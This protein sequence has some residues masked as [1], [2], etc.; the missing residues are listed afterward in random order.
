MSSVGV[1]VLLALC[2]P[3][4]CSLPESPFYGSV[5]ARR[6]GC[7]FLLQ[8]SFLTQ[9]S[10]L[11]LLCLLQWQ[12]DALPLSHWG[13]PKCLELCL[14]QKA[15]RTMIPRSSLMSSVLLLLNQHH[16]TPNCYFSRRKRNKKHFKISSL[17]LSFPS[18]LAHRAFV[19]VVGTTSAT[20]EMNR[21]LQIHPRAGMWL[22]LEN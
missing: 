17:S 1:C 11:G 16:L 18:G 15:A 14:S 9:G 3:T 4:D 20:R 10:N 12:A 5:L 19:F 21:R 6:V 7:H 2:D 22:G 8:G 13:S